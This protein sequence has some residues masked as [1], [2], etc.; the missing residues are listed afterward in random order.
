MGGA[1]KGVWYIYKGET[2]QKGFGKNDFL[3]V[4]VGKNKITMVNL[5]LL[6]EPINFESNSDFTLLSEGLTP[7]ENS[8][9]KSLI[10][11]NQKYKDYME[12][13]SRIE[14]LINEYFEENNEE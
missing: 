1:P 11:K 14:N 5:F 4:P 3:Y 8:L 2:Q 9:T 13:K 7:I 12:E 10:K 6:E